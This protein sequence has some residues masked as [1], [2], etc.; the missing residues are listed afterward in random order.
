MNSAW[1]EKLVGPTIYSNGTQ[2]GRQHKLNF[3][4]DFWVT[5]DFLNDV[6]NVSLNRTTIASRSSFQFSFGGTTIMANNY[7]DVVVP[8]PGALFSE[9]ISIT[10]TPVGAFMTPGIYIS[11]I[12][13]ADNLV[14]VRF[15]NITSDNIAMPN[16]F[17]NLLLE[18]PA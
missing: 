9:Q 4:N 1:T 12:V 6:I 10:V 2:I 13:S 14:G 7:Q 17:F 8:T 15:S 18:K 3:S 11:A 5:K 16:T